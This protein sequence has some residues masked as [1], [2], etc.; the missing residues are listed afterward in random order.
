MIRAVILG[1]G[2][3]GGVPRLGDKWGECDPENPK[4]RRRR[5]ALLVQRFAPDDPGKVTQIV[6]DTG[7]DFA[8]QMLDAGVAE[9]DAIFYTHPHADHIHGIDDVRQLVFNRGAVMPVWADAA[10]GHALTTRF[11]YIFATPPGSQYPPVCALNLIEGEVQVDGAGGGIRMRPFTV[12]HGRIE[13][14]GFR[15]QTRAGDQGGLVYLPDVSAIPD[16][17]WPVIRGAEV[18]I[19]D[20]LRREPHP[21]HAHLAQTLEWFD[22]SGISDCIITDM[23]IDLDYEKVMAETP[24]HIRPA[25]DGLVVEVAG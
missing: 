19:C 11:S 4:N 3:S 20:A 10:T 5:C 17:A 1:C 23:H 6:I 13:A 22:H 16:A 21:S 14:L 8:N 18:F 12:Q 2:S 25:H 15:I 9:L 7:P 24:D